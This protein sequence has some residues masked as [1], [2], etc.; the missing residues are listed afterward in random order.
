[1]ATD[2]AEA[3]RWYRLAAEQG[4]A[5]AQRNLGVCYEIGFG[6]AKDCVEAYA[7]LNAAAA[8]GSPGAAERR[9][10]LSRGMSPQQMNEAKRK[11]PVGAARE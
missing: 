3:A 10:A 2:E 4:H 1:M 6:V 9:D 5:M 8:G 11:R 7:W